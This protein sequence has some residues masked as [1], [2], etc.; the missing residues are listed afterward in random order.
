[1]KN[2][3]IAV[4][5]QENGKYYAYAVPVSGSDNLLS[6]LAIKGITHANI[7]EN[8]KETAQVVEMWNASY[9]DNGTYMFEGVS[10]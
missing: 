1:M 2:T 6:R 8:K 7:C 10:A 3:Y 5:V 9:K 4:T